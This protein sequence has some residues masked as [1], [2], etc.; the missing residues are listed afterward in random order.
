MGTEKFVVKCYL[1]YFSQWT[2]CWLTVILFEIFVD[3]KSR[4]LLLLLF[5]DQVTQDIKEV[6]S[7]YIKVLEISVV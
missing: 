6:P 7:S 4:L 3:C 1:L 5:R 2:F